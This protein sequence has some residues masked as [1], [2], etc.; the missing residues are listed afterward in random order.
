MQGTGSKGLTDGKRNASFELMRIICM[1]MVVMLHYLNGTDRLLTYAAPLT[2]LRIA[3]T[4]AEALC[5]VAVNAFVLLSGFFLSTSRFRIARLLR[6]QCEIWFYAILVPVILW[7]FG[8]PVVGADRYDIRYYLLP[9]LSG[10][11]WFMTAYCIMYLFIPL[12]NRAVQ[13]M[14]RR[15][16]HSLILLLLIPFCIIKSICPV[17]L[18]FDRYGYDFGWFICLY[19]TGACLKKY[20]FGR[21]SDVRRGAA[22]YLVSAAAITILTIALKAV[23]GRIGGLSH[24]LTIPLHYNF[25]AV[26]T[27]SIGFF[28]LFA[29]IRIPDGRAAGVIRFLSG[30]VLAVYL[31]HGHIDLIDAW[32]YYMERITGP[33]PAGAGFILHGL[34]LCIL[35]LAISTAADTLRGLLFRTVRSGLRDTAPAKK[36]A[37]VLDTVD[38]ALNE[39]GSGRA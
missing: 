23:S 28:A 8:Q 7:A 12:M 18:S 10:T 30:H 33:A 29:H 2:G 24:A 25:I 34:F 9:V 36:L 38:A 4:A 21:L 27:A 17:L 14:S 3:G 13:T 26:Y 15:G 16:L 20:G 37:A 11:Y 19:L 31:I 5:I 35:V 39:G 1:L 32:E 22:L 6:L